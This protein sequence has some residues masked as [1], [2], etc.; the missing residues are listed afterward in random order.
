MTTKCNRDLSVRDPVVKKPGGLVFHANTATANRSY[1]H[2]AAASISPFAKKA[3]W[4]IYLAEPFMRYLSFM[5]TSNVVAD[6][7]L[8]MQHDTYVWAPHK[9]IRMETGDTLYADQQLWV[10]CRRSFTFCSK[11][12][13]TAKLTGE[14]TVGCLSCFTRR[15]PRSANQRAPMLLHRVVLKDEGPPWLSVPVAFHNISLSGWHNGC[16]RGALQNA[17]YANRYFWA[18]GP[19]LLSASEILQS[20]FT[21]F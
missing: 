11:S 13:T 21:F 4:I 5:I 20:S 6:W 15:G 16:S 2:C 19:A 10:H 7:F 9:S 8:W 14:L 12:S 3:P 17:E 18:T 1:S